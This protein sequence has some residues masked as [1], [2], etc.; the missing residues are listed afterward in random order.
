MKVDKNTVL[1][2]VRKHIEGRK[3]GGATLEVLAEGVRHKANWWYVYV[4]PSF[5][6][7]RRFEYYETLAQ[8][9]TELLKSEKLIVMLL[10]S[11][12]Q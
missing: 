9:E 11:I 10:P 12:P 4:R 6:P 3:P 5:E 8:V 7:P 1:A 2:A